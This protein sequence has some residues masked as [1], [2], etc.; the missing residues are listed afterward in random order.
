MRH[1]CSLGR[2]FNRP[3]RSSIARPG[4]KATT[5]F[6]GTFTCSPVRG[7]RAFRGLRFLISNTP[8]LRSSMRPFSTNVSVMPS[9]TL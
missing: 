2:S 8:K 5:I 9:K 7:L 6:A 4:L 1:R 3:T